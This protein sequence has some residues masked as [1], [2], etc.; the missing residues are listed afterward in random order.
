MMRTPTGVGIV[1]FNTGKD[2]QIENMIVK[3]IKWSL[4]NIIPHK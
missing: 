3:Q 2:M 1:I 4:A